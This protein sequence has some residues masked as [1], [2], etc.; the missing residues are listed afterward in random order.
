MTN[1][2]VGPPQLEKH[3]IPKWVYQKYETY[4]INMEPPEPN[5]L[6]K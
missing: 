2:S 5:S 4:N 1:I 3:I 6:E